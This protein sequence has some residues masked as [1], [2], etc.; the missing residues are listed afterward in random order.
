MTER[1]GRE[2]LAAGM[3][4]AKYVGCAS[5][6]EQQIGTLADL[7]RCR[8]DGLWAPLVAFAVNVCAPVG[9]APLLPRRAPVKQLVSA[10][11]DL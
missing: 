10:P 1:P 11:S 2:E 3:V 4:L 7:R 9:R 5:V 6:F 8:K